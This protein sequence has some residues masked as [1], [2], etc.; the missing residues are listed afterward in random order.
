MAEVFLAEALKQPGEERFRRFVG[1]RRGCTA[2]WPRGLFGSYAA[3]M[4]RLP[5][6]TETDR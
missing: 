2:E 1:L 4:P 5:G 3:W 6:Y